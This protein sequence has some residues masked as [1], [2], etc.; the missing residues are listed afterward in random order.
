MKPNLIIVVVDMYVSITVKS[1]VVFKYYLTQSTD[2]FYS[3][4]YNIYHI[5][6]LDESDKDL[7]TVNYQRV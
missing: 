5:R 7:V 3:N 2:K 4:I 1:N 6:I